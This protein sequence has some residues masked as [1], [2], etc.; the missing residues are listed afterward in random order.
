MVRKARLGGH[1][2]SDYIVG[3]AQIWEI[4]DNLQLE[5]GQ[6]DFDTMLTIFTDK[7]LG[8]PV[9]ARRF[10][11][12]YSHVIVDEYQDNSDVQARMLNKIVQ[13]GRLTAVGDDDQCIYEFRG[14]SPGNFERLK[15]DYEGQQQ[16]QRILSV[17]EETLII[18]HRSTGNILKVAAAFLSKDREYRKELR[19]E[20]SDGDPVEL[21]KCHDQVQQAKAIALQMVERRK[22]GVDWGE[23]ACLFRCFKFGQLGSLNSVLQRELAAKS[24]PFVVVGGKTIFERETVLDLLAY[25]RLA[26]QGSRNDEA[27]SRVINKPSRRLPRD[28]MIPLLEEFARANEAKASGKPSHV[29]LED[30]ARAMNKTAIGLS[31]SRHH[32]LTEFLALVDNLRNESNRLLL[33][34]LLQYIWVQSGL[35]NLYDKKAPAPEE[36]AHK[37]SLEVRHENHSQSAD[38]DATSEDH[39]DLSAITDR[40]VDGSWKEDGRYFPPEIKLL[41]ELAQR[42]VDEWKEREEKVLQQHRRALNGTNKEIPT[43]V[44]LARNSI[45]QNDLPLEDL[46]EHIQDDIILAP[47]ALGRPVIR[48]FLAEIALQQS[49]EEDES[50]L[51]NHEAGKVSISTIHRAKGLEWKDV[52]VPFFNDE[53]MPT[54]PRED[55]HPSGDGE[56]HV[57]GCSARSGN[58]CDRSCRAFFAER[59]DSKK[60]RS[61]AERHEDE[62]RRLAHVA[63]T[64]AKDRLVFVEIGGYNRKDMQGQPQET[65]FLKDLEQFPS[66]IFKKVDKVER[67]TY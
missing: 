54:K 14:A 22:Q 2:K 18:N 10:H 40:L 5:T 13:G 27:F 42:H 48:S 46:P 47:D 37:R 4:Y 65:P 11:D 52:Y 59:D 35:E 39:V 30:A 56:R 64:R 55:L 41:L 61:A 62:E 53:L 29:Y 50:T 31:K 58:R 43:L 3:D 23:M 33:P 44:E 8:N 15:K 49:V 32:G 38:S 36:D 34:E 24:I 12:M 57:R 26:T 9:I 60:K 25:T 66:S 1:S 7:V 45:K 17:Q 63:A 67:L 20:R 16:G 19:P 6:I 51:N 28:K 21:W